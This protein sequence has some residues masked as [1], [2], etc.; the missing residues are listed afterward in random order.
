MANYK[1]RTFTAV[2]EE[3]GAVKTATHQARADAQAAACY[4]QHFP[5]NPRDTKVVMNEIKEM[6]PDVDWE[7]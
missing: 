3:C 4:E 2:C 5:K 7:S 6:F 1:G